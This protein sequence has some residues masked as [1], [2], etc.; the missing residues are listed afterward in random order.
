ML[1]LTQLHSF[2]VVAEELNFRKA[3]QKLNL[4]QPPLSR[5]VRLLEELLWGRPCLSGPAIPY[6]LP[7]LAPCFWNRRARCW[8]TPDNWRKWYGNGE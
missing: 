7:A 5:Q 1:N 6:T 4:T 8:P 3:A 2:I